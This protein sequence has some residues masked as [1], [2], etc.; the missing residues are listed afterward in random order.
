MFLSEKNF[1]N[2]YTKRFEKV[3]GEMIH[4][5]HRLNVMFFK[6]LFTHKIFFK[7]FFKIYLHDKTSPEKSDHKKW[8]KFYAILFFLY[9]GTYFLYAKVAF[10]FTSI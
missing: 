1:A 5:Y 4:V 8:R 7:C 3:S 10:P 2:L 6:I 9:F